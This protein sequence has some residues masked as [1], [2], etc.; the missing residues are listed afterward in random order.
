MK[1]IDLLKVLAAD[2]ESY[3][4]DNNARLSISGTYVESLDALA[5]RP[6]GSLI[7]L[8]WRGEENPDPDNDFGVVR[9]E[10]GIY[11]AMNTGL[12]L[13]TGE[14]LWASADGKSL[15]ERSHK[16]RDRVRSIVLADDDD[17][18]RSFSYRGCNQVVTPEG[19]PL[20]A[21]LLTF[22]IMAAI[23][24]PEYRNINVIP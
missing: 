7:I 19:V 4:S 5:A 3:A 9:H 14:S 18:E 16:V 20:R 2:L 17:S 15:L 11:I 23:T 6:S 8:E 10:I 13:K 21:Y 22:Q 1:N 12:K 24:Q